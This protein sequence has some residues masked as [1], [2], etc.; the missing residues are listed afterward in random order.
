[1]RRGDVE[2]GGDDEDDEAEL[3]APMERAELGAASVDDEGEQKHVKKICGL[4]LGR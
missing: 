4:G 3:G 2:D 1:M